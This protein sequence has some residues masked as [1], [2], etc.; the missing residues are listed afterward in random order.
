[1]WLQVGGACLSR[2]KQEDPARSM[3]LPKSK[4]LTLPTLFQSYSLTTKPGYREAESRTRARIPRTDKGS[5][6]AHGAIHSA[7][8]ARPVHPPTDPHVLATAPYV[9]FRCRL[10][11]EFERYQFLP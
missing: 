8:Q 11:D 10:A 4:I 7:P 9:Q 3:S 1:M 5:K 6:R 2:E